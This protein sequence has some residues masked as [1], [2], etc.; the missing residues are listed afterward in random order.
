MPGRALA[1]HPVSLAGVVLATASA[2]A[3]LALLVA[4]LLGLFANPYA[5][6]VVF[7]A[8]PALLVTGLLLIPFGMWL[9]RRRV[10]RHPGSER[11]WFVIDFRSAATRR[12]AVL[13]T[14]LTALNVVILLLAG[15]GSLHSMES[16]SFCGQT[17]HDPDASAVHRV[18]ACP[19][20]AGCTVACHVGE[21]VRQVQ[22]E[23]PAGS[24][25]TSSPEAV[26][27]TD[28]RRRGLR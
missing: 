4:E 16:P 2:V 18:A 21:G 9:E 8:L 10:L 7:V 23:R 15:Y 17:C 26:S 14:A 3:F 28:S 24:S 11:D 13:F 20:L 5:A 6:L 12:R 1:R 19:A 27:S 25:T 22:D